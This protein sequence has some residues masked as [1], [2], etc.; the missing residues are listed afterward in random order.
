MWWP[1]FYLPVLEI[2]QF[3]RD[4]SVAEAWLMAQEPYLQ[5][6]DFGVR[7]QSQ[8]VAEWLLNILSGLLGVIIESWQIQFRD[9]FL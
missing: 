3:A 1:M 2:Y 9:Y 4:A 6:Q 8:C 5:N 7:L